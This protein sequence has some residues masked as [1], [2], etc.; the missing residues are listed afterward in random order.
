MKSFVL[1]KCRDV[2]S[3]EA[4]SQTAGYSIEMARLLC[5]LPT[6]GAYEVQGLRRRRW[7]AAGGCPCL[8][9]PYAL[10]RGGAVAFLGSLLCQSAAYLIGNL[11]AYRYTSVWRWVGGF[12]GC[13]WGLL[14]MLGGVGFMTPK[15]RMTAVILNLC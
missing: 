10:T 3:R 9:P 7:T 12:L 8:T 13:L 4:H 11:N 14:L 1:G 5:Q 2:P 6:G 15:D